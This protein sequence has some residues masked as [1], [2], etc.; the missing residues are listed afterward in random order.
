MNRIDRLFGILLLL[1][2][3]RRVRAQDIA[4]R[5]SI[6][7]RT[8]YR[9]IS[10]LMQLGVPIV[11]QAGEGYQM[12]DGYYLPPLVFTRDEAKALF[13]GVNLLEATGN[14]PHDASEVLDKLKQAIP[15]P[16]LRDTLPQVDIIQFYKQ[17]PAIDIN[18]KLLLT[19]QRAISEKRVMWL[20]YRGWRNSDTTERQ[21]EPFKLTSSMSTWYVS[22]YCRLRQAVRDFRVERIEDYHLL[23]E[24]FTADHSAPPQAPPEIEIRLRFPLTM[25]RW[26]EE[27]QHYGF[28]DAS[29]DE[30]HIT[31][32]YS[33][34]TLN[35]IT[36]WILHWGAQVQVLSPQPLKNHLHNELQ[37]ML[38][39]LT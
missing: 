18:D 17:R 39:L 31:M 27:Q 29:A 6:S 32:R 9:D 36:G 37:K 21:I 26:V 20:R 13:L 4:E 8:V 7:E 2:S 25:Q 33:V 34:H 35:E 30:T 10:A 5:Y 23:G 14:L 22:A 38:S 3:R 11:S 1:Q 16:I 19:L 28:I 12:M 15:Q 24:Q